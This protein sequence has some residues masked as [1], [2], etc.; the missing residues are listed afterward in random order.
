MTALHGTLYMDSYTERGTPMMW[1][2]FHDARSDAVGQPENGIE[3]LL[4]LF[5]EKAATREMI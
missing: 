4:P 2:L 5:H 3:A 1:S